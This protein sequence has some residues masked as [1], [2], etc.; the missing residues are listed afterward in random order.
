M[1]LQI[2]FISKI[3]KDKIHIYKGKWYAK[4]FV[5]FQLIIHKYKTYKHEGNTSNSVHA[6]TDNYEMQTC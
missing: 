4:I 2:W 3:L 1:Y 6:R 5:K